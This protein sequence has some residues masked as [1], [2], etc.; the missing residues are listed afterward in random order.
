MNKQFSGSRCADD[1]VKKS[2]HFL[3]QKQ[4]FT[5]VGN[6]TAVAKFFIREN[7]LQVCA[8]QQAMIHGVHANSNHS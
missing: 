1:F 7:F 5:I 6:V 3:S 4:K 8:L 2:I